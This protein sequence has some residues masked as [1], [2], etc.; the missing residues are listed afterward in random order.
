M[1]DSLLLLAIT[2][3]QQPTITQ[4]AKA[5]TTFRPVINLPT[6]THSKI[7]FF[8][9]WSLRFGCS[10]VAHNIFLLLEWLGYFFHTLLLSIPL[11]K[12]E[13]VVIVILSNL[14][15]QSSSGIHRSSIVSSELHPRGFLTLC[16]GPFLDNG[17]GGDSLPLRVE[18]SK[19]AIDPRAK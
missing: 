16:V 3:N 9:L 5:A 13:T 15:T 17:R 12:F 6:A 1:W 11:L 10:F 18:A 8:L 7:G 2:H 19:M 4:P 14:W